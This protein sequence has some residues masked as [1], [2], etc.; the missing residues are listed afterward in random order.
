MASGLTQNFG[1]HTKPLHAGMCSRNGLTAARLAKRGWT[2]A[3]NILESPV[4]W[5]A[6]FLG[7]GHFD[8]GMMVKDLGTTWASSNHLKAYPCCG[9]NHGA[10]DA[11][12]GL[13]AE[14]PFSVAEVEDVEVAG[15]THEARDVVLL[16]PQPISAF[17]G[18]FS[19]HYTIATA[20]ID[21]RIDVDSY[22]EDKLR[23]PEYAEARRKVR[24]TVAP[25]WQTPLA[26]SPT[27]VTVRLRSG[28][29]LQRTVDSHFARGT[30]HNPLTAQE[31]MQKFSKNAQ[32]VLEAKQAQ[33]ALEAWWQIDTIP[34]I[35]HALS[36]VAGAHRDDP[37]GIPSVSI[38]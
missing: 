37:R 16:Y 2:A 26:G 34:D 13:M 32:Y 17:Q 12:L 11:L 5:S 6:S 23:R 29:V 8:P 18:K 22:Q 19:I 27:T 15:L 31:Q 24:V 4:G 35:R 28:E 20:L 33:E 10:L 1:T 21:G 14:R 3:D 30:R 36:L 9:T 25:R 7:N 38:R